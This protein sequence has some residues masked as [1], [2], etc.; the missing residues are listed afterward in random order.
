MANGNKVA[1]NMY[2]TKFK[3]RGVIVY[4]KILAIESKER[5]PAIILQENGRYEVLIAISAALKSAF[6]NM[7]LRYGVNEDQIIDL[8]DRIIDQA[9]EDNLAI[10]DVL[11]FLQKLLVGECGKLYDRMDMPLFFEKF[12]AY[13]QE[14]HSSLLNIRDEQHTQSKVMGRGE[15]RETTTDERKMAKD[16]LDMAKS[17]QVDDEG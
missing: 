16:I 15:E 5:I 6:N 4:D 17:M 9:H 1:V 11:L 8:A 14:R 13:R 10:E 2:L 12:E 7:N 3:E